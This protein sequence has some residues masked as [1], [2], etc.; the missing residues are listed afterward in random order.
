MSTPCNMEFDALPSR[1]VSCASRFDDAG[2]YD[3]TRTVA[4]HP[5]NQSVEVF[6]PCAHAH[7]AVAALASCFERCAWYE[8]TV[9]LADLLTPAFLDRY[10]RGGSTLHAMSVNTPIDHCNSIAFLPSGWLLLVVDKDTV[11]QL[12]LTASAAPFVH[13]PRWFRIAVDTSAAAFAPGHATYDRL[14]WCVTD[15]VPP[16]T[17]RLVSVRGTNILTH[18]ARWVDR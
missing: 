13:N 14:M 18:A 3:H 10:A 16:V 7:S 2:L 5:F 4:A 12:G 6:L 15:R 9:P 17:L 8:V 11:E 1:L